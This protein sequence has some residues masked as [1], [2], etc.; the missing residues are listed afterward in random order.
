MMHGARF[1][2]IPA[3][4]PMVD[5]AMYEVLRTLDQIDSDYGKSKDEG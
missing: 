4:F 3:A 2:D 5:H 1:R